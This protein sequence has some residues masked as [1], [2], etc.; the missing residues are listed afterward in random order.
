M[1]SAVLKICRIIDR[2]DGGT[3][4]LYTIIQLGLPPLALGACL[5][6]YSHC[7]RESVPAYSG[8]PSLIIEGRPPRRP[9][10]HK[11]PDEGVIVFVI[12]TKIIRTNLTF[13]T[14]VTYLRLLMALVTSA[15][16]EVTLIPWETWGPHI[17]AC[18]ELHVCPK[19]DALIGDRL[20]TLVHRM[21]SIFDFNS[22]RIQ[23]A[24]KRTGDS[25]GC[26]IGMTMVKHRSVVPKGRVFKEDV[27]GKLPYISVIRPASTG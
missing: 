27:I 14:V 11:S 4:S 18:F 5:L 8:P 12:A 21:L 25:I 19:V 9:L 15:S 16:S 22:M 3:L 26:S 10:F 6:Y 23:D 1:V 2:P 7:M 24:I 17:T 13:L 20:V